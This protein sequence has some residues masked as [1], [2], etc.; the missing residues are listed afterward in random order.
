VEIGQVLALTAV[1]LALGFWRT[2]SGFF[3]Y[4]FAA[5]AVLMAVGFVLA[6]YQLT[7]YLVAA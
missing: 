5:N 2:R 7:G 3:R 1:V 6:G 4:A